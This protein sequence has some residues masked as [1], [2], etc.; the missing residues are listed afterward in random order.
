MESCKFSFDKNVILKLLSE[1]KALAK[2]IKRSYHN[3]FPSEHILKLDFFGVLPLLRK[4][5]WVIKI[6][7]KVTVKNSVQFL[8]FGE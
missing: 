7:L 8:C 3:L 2:A 1:K 4:A 5:I 6:W